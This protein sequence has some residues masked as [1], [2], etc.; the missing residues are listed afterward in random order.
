MGFFRILLC[1]T[2]IEL[3]MAEDQLPAIGF[4]TT[5]IVKAA[6][7]SS[8]EQ[9]A[10]E[11]ILSEWVPGG[12]YASANKGSTPALVVENVEPISALTG[13]LKRNLSGYTFFLAD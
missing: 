4:Y 7:A 2:G 1:G 13:V 10:K 12:A 6:T 8:A 11:L 3:P 5:R 9:L